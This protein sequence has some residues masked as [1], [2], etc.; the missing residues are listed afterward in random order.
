MN[1]MQLPGHSVK[2]TGRRSSAVSV[3]MTVTCSA[4]VIFEALAQ[5]S[6]PAA[7][8]PRTPVD[9]DEQL[10]QDAIAANLAQSVTAAVLLVQVPR[11]PWGHSAVEISSRHPGISG[12]CMALPR[13]ARWER[14]Q[15]E[16]G[17]SA[18]TCFAASCCYEE[19]CDCLV[20]RV[21]SLGP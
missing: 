4:E 18:V 12:R 16:P 2:Y 6:P 11:C 9:P 5:P 7:R 19:C 1:F 8:R 10:L 3:K 21:Q 20:Q 17:Y 13:S 15:L 14:E